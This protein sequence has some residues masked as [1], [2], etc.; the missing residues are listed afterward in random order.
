MTIRAYNQYS[1]SSQLS[2]SRNVSAFS[3]SI[4][5]LSSGLRVNKTADDPPTVVISDQLNSQALGLGQAVRNANDAVSITRIVDAS[6]NEA[7]DIVN[8]IKTKASQAASDSQTSSVRNTL[9]GDI[10]KLLAEL[11]LVVKTASFNGHPLLDGGF[12]SKLFQV[13]ASSG[14]TMSL[15][16]ASAHKSKVGFLSAG[17]LS[18]VTAGGDVSLSVTNS[19]LSRTL[20][21]A[22]LTMSYDNTAAHGLGAVADAINKYSGSTDISAQ[23]VVASTSNAAIQAGTTSADFAIN[24]VNIGAVSVL[25]NDSD[26]SLVTA[27]N[28]KTNSHGVTAS[29]NSAGQLQLTSADGRAIKVSGLDAVLPGEDLSTFGYVQI[30]QQGAQDLVV[31]DL[32]QG[33]AVSFSSNLKMTASVLTS[34]DSTLAYGSV[35]GGS[36]TLAAGWQAGMTVSGANLSGNISTTTNSTLLAGSVLASGSTV[37]A[38]SILGGTAYNSQSINST[39]NN[40]LKGGSI[41]NIGSMLLSGTYLTNDISTSG[42]TIIAGTILSGN[43]TLNASATISN[44]M[45]LLSGS[46]VASGSTFAVNSYLGGNFNLSGSMTANSNMT[47]T[48]GSNIVDQNGVTVL[49]AGSTIGGAAALAAGNLSVTE[50]MLVKSGST[51]TAATELATGSTIGGTTILNGNHTATADI[52]LAA[53]SIIASGSTVKTATTLTNNLV[54]TA[55]IIKAGEITGQDYLT[56]G[57]N[58]ITNAMT[59]KSG[60]ILSNGSSMAANSRSEA[61]FKLGS[62]SAMRLDDINVLTQKD[63]TAAMAIADAALADLGQIKAAAGAAQ[64]TFL[65][66]AIVAGGVK[67]NIMAARAKMLDLDFASEAVTYSKMQ[68]LMRAS[69]FA[70]TQAN[71]IPGSVLPILQGGATNEKTSQFFVSAA[72]STAM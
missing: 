50:N 33:M 58:N 14:E 48:S 66:M 10:N 3:S 5:K 15:N 38:S 30:Y 59:L 46:T 64:D 49:A 8:S 57:A 23:A 63:A 34:V 1:L 72:A 32:S 27:I 35:L 13:G 54:T 11:S 67:N 37:A 4:E 20:S 68:I 62:Q 70:L 40:F 60:S 65:G 51:L 28:A 43:K 2:F 29:T 53:G 42:G 22:G 61:E 45:L 6:V 24:N 7:I 39:K 9:Q 47:L 55:G 56:T 16:V 31:S 26:A 52:Y 36:S 18:L 69:A 44:D 19:R 41:L 21:I 71:A 17:Q 12:T 25:A